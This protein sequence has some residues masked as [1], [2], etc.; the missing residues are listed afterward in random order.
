MSEGQDTEI[1]LGT[2]K[3]LGLFFGLVI[4]CALFF[5][6]GFSMGRSSAKSGLTIEERP[7]ATLRPQPDA[8]PKADAGTPVRVAPAPV[9]PSDST[10]QSQAPANAGAPAATSSS[11]T[12]AP[13]EMMKGSPLLSGA[14]YTVQIAAVSK[15][16]DAEALVSALKTKSYPVFI[17][18]NTSD[19]LFHVQI[20]PFADI[21]DA[22]AM[23]AKLTSDGYNPIVKR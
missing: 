14:A 19:K 18:P 6:L 9:S 8:G 11:A 17:A 13:P 15:Q 5:A 23:K 1:T 3:L 22:E 16:E 7:P 20:G 12:G 21:K 4:V 10:A 2:G